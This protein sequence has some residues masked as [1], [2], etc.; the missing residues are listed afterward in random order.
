MDFSRLKYK[1]QFLGK[2]LNLYDKLDQ[3]VDEN[4]QYQGVLNLCDKTTTFRTNLTE[5]EKV[6]CKRLL[7]NLL[8]LK[9]VNYDD[10]FIK[11]CSNL[12][13][14]LYFN[15]KKPMIS[16]D[17]IKKIFELPNSIE[18]EGPRYN[19]CPYFSFNDKIH[20][21]EKLMKLRIFN[22]NADT[23]Q[24]MLKGPI[25]SYDC[26]LIRYIYKCILIYRDMNSRYCSSGKD[27]TDE[28]KN[29]CDIIGQFDKLYTPYISNNN[30]ITHKFP[31]LTSGTLINNID[32]CSLEGIYSDETQLGTSITKGV[33]TAL[34]AMVGIPPFLALM[35]K[36]TRF[37]QFFRSRYKKGI[38]NNIGENELFYPT[39]ENMNNSSDHTR[40]NVLY[41]PVGN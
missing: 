34:G 19:Y 26:S 3:A 12:Y 32:G 41:G 25:K 13:V 1:Y 21:P 17:I 36:F 38:A 30:K 39:T 15:I 16:N 6:V 37:G 40:Y 31:E 4:G 29:S 28:N 24:S 5:V 27:T 14:W 11:G 18:N 8:Q 7:N 9:N 2:I 35:Y 23:F 33:S 20:N 22:D 10:D